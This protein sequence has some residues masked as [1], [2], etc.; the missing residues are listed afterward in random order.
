[1]GRLDTTPSAS[2]A[3]S[4]SRLQLLC[5]ALLFST[6]GAAIKAVS[7]DGWQVA[8]F[9]S[10][11]AALVLLAL[12]P[13]ARRNWSWR[14][15][16]VGLSYAI[17]LVLFVLSNKLT[18]AANAIFLQSAA[19]LYLLL[20]GPWL[21]KEPIRRSDLIL[22]AI[23]GAGMSL[24]FVGGET[25]LTTAPHPFRGNVVAVFAGITWALTL[26]GLR[27]IGSRE[28]G[29]QAGMATV[30]AGNALACLVCLPKALPLGSFP[31]R[32][33]LIIGYLGAFQIG[34]AYVF[35]TR[36]MRVVPALEASLLLMAEPALSPV[37]AALVH[38]EHPAPLAI[39]GG[40]LILSAT[41][42]R[43][44]MRR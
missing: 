22:V 36:A 32:D 13:G 39:L 14:V 26:V 1:L 20:L 12:V 33:V 42:A 11:V 44:L 19:P 21:L 34:L 9:R 18:T 5:A 6:G 10:G 27:W 2:P 3:G 41:L 17:T 29:A 31:V 43:T 25:A 30:L 15:P 23:V 28:G 4:L 8:C 40:A 24:F 7:M 37:W 35:L 16:L 38:G